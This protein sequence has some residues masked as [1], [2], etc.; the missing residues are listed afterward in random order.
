MP[1][2]ELVLRGRRSGPSA[3]VSV[4]EPIAM[5]S[6]LLAGSFRTCVQDAGT[7]VKMKAMRALQVVSMVRVGRGPPA[8]SPC[9]LR[10]CIAGWQSA[11]A[12]ESA[13]LVS[14]SGGGPR[15]R[16]RGQAE[17]ELESISDG[18]GSCRRCIRARDEGSAWDEYFYPC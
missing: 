5:P 15:G 18:Q 17:G 16:A 2:D 6:D 9:V 4:P 10:A 11:P 1:R 8:G 14:T 13:M 7:Q 12:S 3:A